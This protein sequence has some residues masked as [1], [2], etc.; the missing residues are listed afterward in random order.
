MQIQTPLAPSTAA[1]SPQTYLVTGAAGFIGMHTCEALLDR[2]DRVVGIDNMNAYYDVGL[3]RARLARLLAR[4]GFTF[5]EN[6]IADRETIARVFAETQPRIVVHLAA[7]AGVRYSTTNPHV[8]A[9][10]NL[11]GFMNVLEGCR[12]SKV[13]HLVYASSSSVYGVNE[14]MPFSEHDGTNHPISIYAA[15]KK[16]NELMAHSY[17]H[18]FALPTTALRF[19]TVYGP[20]GRPDM[21]LFLFTHAMLEGRAID[22]FNHG[23]MIRDFTFVDDIVEGVLRVAEKPATP[24]KNFDPLAPD[25][26]ISSAPY[27]VF[28]IGNS[29]PV[30]LLYYIEALEKTLGIVATKN[31]LP[32]QPGD[33]LAT[34]SDTQELNA[35]IG[36]KPRMPVEEGVERFVHWYRGYYRC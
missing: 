14:A 19:F 24:S 18:L 35:W 17:S 26:S 25:P 27:R 33:V 6:D 3:K 4:S 11:I 10:S 23:Q 13:E 31:M 16:A 8:Y 9:Q 2:G 28:N 5:Y 32:L 1:L 15:T 7:Q 30:P 20:W 12:V 29:A 21:S 34:S 22:V 36:F